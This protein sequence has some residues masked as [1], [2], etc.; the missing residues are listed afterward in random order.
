MG[1]GPE[2]PE[3]GERDVGDASP[4]MGLELDL[5]RTGVDRRLREGLECE[6]RTRDA[7]E[8][9]AGASPSEACQP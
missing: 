4:E 3:R 1:V 7:D 6:R 9:R 8:D 5:E 2:P